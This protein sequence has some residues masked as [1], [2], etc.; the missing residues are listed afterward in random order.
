MAL[1]LCP[2]SWLWV[3]QAAQN[4]GI[5]WDGASPP[6]QAGISSHYLIQVCASTHRASWPQKCRDG[7]GTCSCLCVCSSLSFGNPQENETS[8]IFIVDKL[9]D[10][11]PCPEEGLRQDNEHGDRN[12]SCVLI[13]KEQQLWSGRTGITQRATSK[14][15][16]K[17]C[18]GGER[19]D[20]IVLICGSWGVIL[21]TLR[22]PSI[23]NLTLIFLL[24]S[25]VLLLQL[26][27]L[28]VPDFSFCG[29]TSFSSVSEPIPL[30]VE[31]KLW[32]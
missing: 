31:M 2:H 13:G 32:D 21:L 4:H 23:F 1:T 11:Y 3:I 5:I 28:L 14:G 15:S 27:A 22:I 17:T 29:F 7:S 8:V 9:E 25:F 18:Q 24:C 16:C 26:L 12:R 30:L 6:S 10:V 19:M 20:W